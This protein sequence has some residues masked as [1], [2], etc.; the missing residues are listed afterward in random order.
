MGMVDINFI[1]WLVIVFVIWCVCIIFRYL[2]T[3][4]TIKVSK[5]SR[6]FY[7]D[8]ER[9]IKVWGKMQEKGLLK[10]IIKSIFSMTAIMGIVGLVII[11]YHRSVGGYEQNQTLLDYL[12]TGFV[13]GIIESFFWEKNQNRYI[14]LKEDEEESM[15]NDNT[16]NDSENN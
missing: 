2:V 4:N 15:K 12:S 13:L 3:T 1:I 11:L 14:R 7:D 5:I 16:N 6:I 9:F 10:Y 8:D